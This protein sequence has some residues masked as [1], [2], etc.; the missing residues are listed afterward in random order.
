MNW[1][2]KIIR[3]LGIIAIIMGIWFVVHYSISYIY[4]DKK[5]S[6][7]YSIYQPI[8]AILYII[9]GVGILRVKNWARY[10]F[11]GLMVYYFCRVITVTQLYVNRLMQKRIIGWIP[12][13]FIAAVVLISLIFPIISV[14]FLNI[15]KV[16]KCFK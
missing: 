1:H 11:I 14:W 10:V 8:G 16:K 4:F 3:L 13:I 12:E 15:N 9:C 2:L 5:L 7:Y 6:I